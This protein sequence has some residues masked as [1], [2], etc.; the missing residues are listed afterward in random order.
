MAYNTTASL[1][2]LTC[3]DY[4]DF[5]NCQER[6][7]RFSWSNFDS[8]YLD[9]R[10]KVFKKDDNKELRLV[11]NLTMWEADFSQFMRLSNQ[12]VNAPEKFAKEENLT[13]V[14]IATLSKNMDEQLKMVHKI[15][16]CG[17]S[18]QI[19]LCDSAAV[20]CDKPESSS[21][22]VPFYARKKKDEK[23]EQVVY[24]K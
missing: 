12:L 23:F 3:T 18:K 21:W 24:V 14:L 17:T 20:Q 19:D 6:I 13:S 15:W 22:E 4:V 8:K 11:Q 1:D 10:L 9:V 16:L 7:G 2:K 5:G